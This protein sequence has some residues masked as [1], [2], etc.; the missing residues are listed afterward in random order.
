MVHQLRIKKWLTKHF[1][2]N[3]VNVL[4]RIFKMLKCVN[5]GQMV[6]II[7]RPLKED[8]RKIDRSLISWR[9][10]GG[11]RFGDMSTNMFFYALSTVV[12][13][14]EKK[15]KSRMIS[16]DFLFFTIHCLIP[17]LFLDGEVVYVS[18]ISFIR[19]QPFIRCANKKILRNIQK[20]F[21]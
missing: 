10:G 2:V 13:K 9:G 7:L 12:E 3:I 1:T 5:I 21:F 18:F 4:F 19:H 6:W 17:P 11:Q 16:Q 15:K 8:F 20:C 14:K